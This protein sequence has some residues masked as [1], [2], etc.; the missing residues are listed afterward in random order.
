MLPDP[1]RLTRPLTVEE[2]ATISHHHR[3]AASKTLLREA[4]AAETVNERLRGRVTAAQ[5]VEA[6]L[7]EELRTVS[8]NADRLRRA[9]VRADAKVRTLRHR[10]EETQLAQT[11]SSFDQREARR[12]RPGPKPKPRVLVEIETVE[13]ITIETSE[14]YHDGPER[15]RLLLAEIDAHREAKRAQRD[16]SHAA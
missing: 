13:E 2:Y 16:A 14:V 3:M 11:L 4:M 1:K 5:G 7:R 6:E 12:T 10:L 9:L 15:M 8:R